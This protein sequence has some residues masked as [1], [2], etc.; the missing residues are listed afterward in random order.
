MKMAQENLKPIF[1]LAENN[2]ALAVKLMKAQADATAE[3]MQGNLVHVKALAETKD[4]NAAVEMQQ[5]YVE[6]LNEKLVTTA[7]ENA[8][9]IEAAVTE[10]GKIFEGSIAEVQAQAKKTA[11]SIEK[12]ISKAG[13]KA[14]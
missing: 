14:A 9:V 2:T 11:E 13:K 7:K 6:S 10:A 1:K 12:E 8:A 5:K 4:L 3:V